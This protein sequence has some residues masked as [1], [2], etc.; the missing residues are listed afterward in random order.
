MAAR[1]VVVVLSYNGLADTR[2][3]L[4]S[5]EPAMRPDAIALLVDN[6][7]TD[8]TAAIVT[9]EFPWCQ[10]LR[11]QQNRGPAAGNN[12]GLREALRLGAD[13]ALLLNNDT[14]VDSALIDRMRDAVTAHGDYSVI[15]PVIKFM[16]DPGIVMT[17]GTMFNVPGAHGFFV[18]KPVPV[19]A[20]LPPAITPV[21]IVNGCCM[22]IRADAVR[23]VGLFDE[24]LFMYHDE[25]DYCLRVRAAGRR[26]GVIDHALVWHKGSATS[27]ATGKRSVRYFDARNLVHVLRKHRGAPEHG[28]SR[29]RTWAAYLRYMYYWFDAE[30]DAGRKDSADAVLQGVADGLAGR[31]GPYGPKRR[32]LSLP[33]RILFEAARHR[34]TRPARAS[35]GASSE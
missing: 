3:C 10:L 21:D 22:M 32:L 30:R 35:S 16:D 18:R 34:P 15:G 1:I 14:T 31:R 28:R 2:K 13:W 11:V 23:E 27:I 19:T 7:S 33:F 4:R 20:T 24:S 8:D 25:T 17:D 9:A 29:V 6:G 12:A 5:L 26:L